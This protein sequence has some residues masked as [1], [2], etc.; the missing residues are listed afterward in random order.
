MEIIIKTNK[1]KNTN[2][3]QKRETSKNIIFSV[4]LLTYIFVLFVCFMIY[5]L[6]DLSPLS[7][8]IPAVFGLSTTALGFYSWKAKNENKIKLE[9][10]RIKEEQKLKREFKD[11]NI[12]I[13][14]NKYKENDEA[15]Y[16]ADDIYYADNIISD[17]DVFISNI[18]DE[19]GEG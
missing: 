8:L 11:D 9:I 19:E 3:K 16:Y 4:I 18:N 7:Y 2:Q 10:E 17:E 12:K 14:I 1:N 6:S 13:N 5:K 15:N